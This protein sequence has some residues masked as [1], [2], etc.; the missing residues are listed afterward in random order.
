MDLEYSAD[1]QLKANN[2]STQANQAMSNFSFANSTNSVAFSF[3]G[4]V[5]PTHI[6]CSIR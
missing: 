5:P 3:F 4:N 1:S 6:Q 2:G